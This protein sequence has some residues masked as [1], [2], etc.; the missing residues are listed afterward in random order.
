MKTKN[1]AA[2]AMVIEI[3]PIDRPIDYERN[4]RKWSA[5]AVA[6]VGASLRE[7]GWRQPVV[8]DSAGVIVIGH[9][10]R[11]AA[12]AIGLTECPVHVASDL[13][14]AEIH[15]LGLADNRTHDDAGWIEDLSQSELLELKGMDFDLGLTGFNMRE[16][17]AFTL[18]T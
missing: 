17:D 8:V 5:S 6:K 18:P 13:I 2:S 11:T 7:Y 14:P 1:K 16:I 12:K 4:A 3:W 10:R 15:V 9:L